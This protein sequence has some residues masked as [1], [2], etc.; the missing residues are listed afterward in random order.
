MIQ[1]DTTYYDSDRA[2]A[3][4]VEDTALACMAVV[5]PVVGN[6]LLL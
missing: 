5:E 1:H 4:T 6:M 3:G 2:V